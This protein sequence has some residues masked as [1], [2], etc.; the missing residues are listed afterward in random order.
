MHICSLLVYLQEHLYHRF[1]ISLCQRNNRRYIT[2]TKSVDVLGSRPVYEIPLINISI[3]WL[4]KLLTGLFFQK[5]SRVRLFIFHSWLSKLLTGLFFFPKIQ[6]SVSFYIPLWTQGPV[7]GEGPAG[8]AAEQGGH[9]E[10]NDCDTFALVTCDA[11]ARRL[12]SQLLVR[13]GLRSSH[14]EV[15]SKIKRPMTR[16]DKCKVPPASH[17]WPADNNSERLIYHLRKFG[18]KLANSSKIQ[19]S[20]F[21]QFFQPLRVEYVLQNLETVQV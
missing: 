7:V 15:C 6:P 5:Y 2:V 18:Q 13:P 11:A 14:R 16:C 17:H 4:S 12:R 3:S 21:L 20:K 1:P 10:H 8:Q 9:F 19:S